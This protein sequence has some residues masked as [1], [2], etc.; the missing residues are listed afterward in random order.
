MNR[1]DFLTAAGAVSASAG[2]TLVGD[3][4]NGASKSFLQRKRQPTRQK[5][6]SRRPL[7]VAKVVEPNT[8][9][10]PVKVDM[11]GHMGPER[12]IGGWPNLVEV[13]ELA[14]KH[15]NEICDPN[16]HYVPYVG[17]TLGRKPPFF[18]K[19]HSETDRGLLRHP[20]P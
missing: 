9:G 3:E 13:A 7:R 5:G 17:A 2:L 18:G 8:K 12:E 4:A 11:P 15:F 1:R 14:I 6:M 20:P 10:G 19:N 16:Y